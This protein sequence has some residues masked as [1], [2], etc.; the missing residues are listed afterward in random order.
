MRAGFVVL[1]DVHFAYDSAAPPI[2]GG[3]SLQL[4]RGW[5]GVVG[6]NGGGKTT[7]L[8]ICVGELQPQRGLV[9][10]PEPAA[11]CEQRTDVPPAALAALVAA[12]DGEARALRDQL[13]VQ[14]DWA[15]RWTTLSCGERK[16]AQLAVALWGA[17]ALLAVDEPTN[18]IDAAARALLVRALRGFRGVGLLVSHDRELLDVLC[19][20][21]LFLD[22]PD[23][24][25]RPGGYGAGAAQAARDRAHAL[26]SREIARRERDRL[27]RE[28]ARRRE[29]ASRA[30]RRRSKRGLAPRDHDAREHI[31]RARVSGKD[32]Q[33]G[34][35][36]RQLDGRLA[37]AHAELESRRVRKTYELGIWMPGARS[38]RDAIVRLEAGTLALGAGRRLELPALAI[39]PDDR[40]AVSGPNGAGK[41]TLVRHL[42][43][44]AQIEPARLT[45]LPQEIAPDAGAAILA[46]VRAL[47]A[48]ELG[49]VMTAV[50]CLGSRPD[51]LLA[52]PAPSP[53][54]LRKLL[55][56]Q[57]LARTPHLVALDEP[58]N[59]LDLPSIECLETALA[60]C[61]CA[62]LL[63][64]HD[65]RF[66]ERLARIEWRLESAGR[67]G[68]VRLRITSA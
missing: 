57:G 26:R 12:R 47:P 9:Q 41:T 10:V 28:V 30:D 17:P 58:T 23:A 62:L 22:P 67:G 37:R 11:L 55:I 66:V 51:R 52:T 50:S 60:D 39:R 4:P 45:S 25:L 68:E 1:R 32:G 18:H 46:A 35:L 54:E 6:P 65:R 20:Q 48:A 13:G 2:L 56:A 5:T 63:V 33:A 36:Q 49:R 43:A 40:I 19:A 42:L 31:D 8:R 15:A 27:A 29:E 24:T 53:G 7:L 44:H 64:S 21:C 61:P 38:R 3:L 59:H 34:R 16:R 14:G